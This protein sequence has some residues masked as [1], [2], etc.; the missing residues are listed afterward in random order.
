[1]PEKRRVQVALTLMP[2]A[3]AWIRVE[4]SK[5]WFKVPAF[6]PV[7]EVLRGALA[8]WQATPTRRFTTCEATVRVPLSV[9]ARMAA[10]EASRQPSE[11]VAPRSTAPLRP[12]S[13]RSS[14]RR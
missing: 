3:E 14:P 10:S 2:G 11:P 8:G 13:A 6:V 12:L 9:F 5:G 7:E 4:H 1:M